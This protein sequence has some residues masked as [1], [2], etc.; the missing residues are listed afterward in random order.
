MESAFT[1]GRQW[2]ERALAMSRAQE[3]S[4]RSPALWGAAWLAYQ[5]GD[6]EAAARYGSE[7][8]ARSDGGASVDRRNG[9]TILG[10]LAV[11]EG[12]PNEAVPLLEEALGIARAV[13]IRWHVATSLLNLGTALLHQDDHAR[14]RQVLAEA[15]AEH[16]VGGDRLFAA[17]CRVELGYAALVCGDLAQGRE[18]FA[19]A[20]ATFVDLRERW[21][22]AEAIRG[23][24]VLAAARG[25]AET[26]AMLTGASDAT[27]ADVAAHFIAPDANL[28]EPFLHGARDT[29]GEREWAAAVGLG[30]ALSTEQAVQF[31]MVDA[32]D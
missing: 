19:D 2:L 12:R 27:Y 11:A 8:I 29:L 13:G 6:R 22:I 25:D 15:V 28:A 30:R 4:F 5:Q 18:C 21:G 31:A 1:E 17:R 20:L 14:A 9:L 26:A 10:H 7:L 32:R 23:F 24:A 3:S 16:E